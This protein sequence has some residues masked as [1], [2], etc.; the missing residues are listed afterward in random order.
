MESICALVLRQIMMKFL[1]NNL[2]ESLVQA[3]VG[4]VVHH[5]VERLN[6]V[7]ELASVII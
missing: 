2:L 4:D 6:S 7:V 3:E 1:P 5:V